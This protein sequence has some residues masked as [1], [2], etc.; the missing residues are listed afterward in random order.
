MVAWQWRF[1][2]TTRALNRSFQVVLLHQL[3]PFTGLNHETHKNLS[4][5]QYS[6]K[7]KFFLRRLEKTRWLPRVQLSSA[8]LHYWTFLGMLQQGSEY[9]PNKLLWLTWIL[10]RSFVSQNLLKIKLLFWIV[11]YIVTTCKINLQ[12][13]TCVFSFALLRMTDSDLSGRSP[14]LANLVVTTKSLT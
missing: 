2:A 13:K 14:Q 5:R 4:I 12:C 3:K 6:T 1:T 10:T 9:R 8:L 11:P 7:T